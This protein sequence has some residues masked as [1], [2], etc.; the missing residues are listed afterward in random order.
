MAALEYLPTMSA[1]AYGTAVHVAFGLAVRL[2]DL[3]GVGDIER[4]FSLDTVDP[5]YGLAGT[6]R[7]D[8]TLRNVQGEIIAIYDVKTG[9]ATISRSRADELRT[10]PGTPVFEL[11]V[12]RGIS[13]KRACLRQSALFLGARARIAGV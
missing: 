5:S 10:A 1:R 4:S 13:R 3:R 6:I 2:Q 11:N 7:T 8:V 12:V 9:D